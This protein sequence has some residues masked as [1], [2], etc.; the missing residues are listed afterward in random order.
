[1]AS[2]ID[3]EQAPTRLRLFVAALVVML[4]VLVVWKVIDY[5][6]QPPPPPQSQPMREPASG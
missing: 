4:T 6:S 3:R 2:A 5:R 1:M